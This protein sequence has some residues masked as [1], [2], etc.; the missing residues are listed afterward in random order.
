MKKVKTIALDLTLAL[1][2]LVA[3]AAAA[4]VLPLKGEGADI[5]GGAATKCAYYTVD[6]IAC[7][8]T[9]SGCRYT[10]CVG[11]GSIST[12]YISSYYLTP[13]G[14]SACGSVYRTVPCVQSVGSG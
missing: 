3:T 7:S 12:V 9:A 14:V 6:P 4:G 8:G 11:G 2:L 13:C 1:G 5:F 10:P